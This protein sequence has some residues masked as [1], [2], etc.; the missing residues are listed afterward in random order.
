[1]DVNCENRTTLCPA[2]FNRDNMRSSTASFPD[3]STSSSTGTPSSGTSVPAK[4]YGWLQHLRN[5]MSSDCSFLAS[6]AFCEALCS[7]AFFSSPPPP[8]PLCFLSSADSTAVSAEDSRWSSRRYQKVCA[9]ESGHMILV[10]VFSGRLTSTS[11]LTRR[12]TNG[13]MR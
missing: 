1:M 11:P 2:S 9:G 8:P 10:S 3:A 7:E 5:C 12:S 6:P 4:R 13:F